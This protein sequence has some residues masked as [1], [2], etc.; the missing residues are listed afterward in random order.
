[1][2]YS[3]WPKTAAGFATGLALATLFAGTALAAHHEEGD[4][5]IAAGSITV[6]ESVAINAGPDKVWGLVRDFKGLANWHPAVQSSELTEGENN[7]SGAVRHLMLGDGG[8]INEKL[9]AWSD[10]EMQFSYEIVDGVLPVS[11]YASTIMVEAEGESSA[12][13]TWKGQFDAAEGTADKDAKGVITNVYRAGLTTVRTMAT[14][15]E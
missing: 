7:K 15:E 3:A 11:N 2:K 14:G 9:T 4:D 13:L 12:K 6:T 10:E 1:M 8:S 5:G